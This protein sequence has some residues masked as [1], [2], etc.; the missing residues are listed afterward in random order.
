MKQATLPRNYDSWKLTDYREERE[1]DMPR[2][3]SDYHIDQYIVQEVTT[4]QI[5]EFFEYLDQM[6]EEKYNFENL[7]IAEHNIVG[8]EQVDGGMVY[9]IQIVWYNMEEVIAEDEYELKDIIKKEVDEMWEDD[10]TTE[11]NYEI[12]TKEEYWG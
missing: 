5:P 4:E 6:Y 12:D 7:E 9:T 3:L 2:I 11:I 10:S 8:Q 1:K